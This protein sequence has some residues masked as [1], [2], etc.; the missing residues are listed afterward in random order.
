M[1][2]IAACPA[3]QAQ[4]TVT[5]DLRGRMLRCRRC[6]QAFA[7]EPPVPVAVVAPVATFAPVAAIQPVPP[8]VAPNPPPTR[9]MVS[10]LTERVGRL[11]RKVLIGVAAGIGIF[12]CAALTFTAWQLVPRKPAV[13][14]N[15]DTKP[16]PAATY[17]R[18]VPTMPD[19]PLPSNGQMTEEVLK[20]VK[21][22]TVHL[23]VTM[24]EG[25][26][27]QGSGFFAVDSGIVLTNAHVVGMLDPD[28]RPPQ[29]IDVTLNSG[30][31]DEK[32]MQGQ[33]LGV[34]RNS[35]LAVLRATGFV[36]SLPTP[37]DVKS[38]QSLALTQKLFVFGFPLGDKLGREISVRESSVASL[39]K[40]GDILS[41]VQ[42]HGGMDP[43]N[44]GGPV[45]DTSGDVVGVAVSGITG[46]SINFAVPGDR[47]RVMLNGRVDALS[48]GQPY[49]IDG[50]VLLPVSVAKVDPLNRMKELAVDLWVGERGEPR[51]PATTTPA[52]VHGDTP[53]AK[54]P[55]EAKAALPAS[56]VALQ[57]LPPGKV[58][59]VQ[60]RWVNG[61][62]ETHWAGAVAYDMPS[63]PIERK[64]AALHLK[65]QAGERPLALVTKTAM[66][67]RDG[68]GEDH[69]IVGLMQSKFV[70][71][72]QGIDPQGTAQV[73]LN[74]REMALD[75]SLDGKTMPRSP[76]LQRIVANFGSLASVLQVDAQGKLV[77]HAI[78]LNRVPVPTRADVAPMH[79][80]IVMSLE[81]VA[82]P[83]PNRMTEPLQ[84]WKATR[85]LPI[86][87]VG[88]YE[89]GSA[90][91]TYTFLGTRTR[92]GR[93][94]AVIG[95]AGAVK[96]QRGREGQ[97]GGR[98]EG[99]AIFDL[100]VGQV[101]Q[102]DARV[103]LDMDTQLNGRAAKSSGI[104][105]VK[106]QRT[107]VPPR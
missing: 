37:L 1:P 102:V 20:R 99:T 85:P 30:E 107:V 74:Y 97:I 93:Q 12:F 16:A 32:K 101:A 6:P 41:K 36:L 50:K 15:A 94:E 31:K 4:Y 96:G 104:M 86:D 84:T 21:R 59:W 73:R 19:K 52:V 18:L 60:P 87:T 75:L 95:L 58:Y 9:P 26:Q 82:V 49:L 56:D 57:P 24:P 51:P 100:G 61:A 98:L 54:T 7:A 38:A 80:Q 40:E 88:R 3:C 62:G 44:S 77:R 33:V 92:D 28:S 81:T 90:D 68:E 106:L 83:I 103:V 55:L 79:D 43:G 47:V 64:A 63:P 17:P 23:R 10:V 71:T 8:P 39:R 91:V 34:D 76:R 13:V 27:S 25:G 5:D 11:P 70:E 35:D 22:A 53:H 78:D 46:T 42:V 45:V 29:S 2:F 67:M 48:L 66:R 72:T 14:A 65:H 69:G 89:I 105:E